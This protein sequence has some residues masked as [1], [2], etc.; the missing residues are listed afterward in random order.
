MKI[1]TWILMLGVLV[2]NACKPNDPPPAEEE[3]GVNLNI[4]FRPTFNAVQLSWLSQ[5]VTGSDDSITFDKVKFLL[6][7][8]TLETKD[9]KLVVLKDVFAYLSLKEGRDSVVLKRVPKGDYKSIRFQIGLDSEVNHSDPA[10]WALTD[11]LS[12][13]LNE[14]HWGWSGGYI[15][16]VIEGYYKNKGANA[17]Y[18][19]HIATE[20]YARTHSFIYDYSISKDA[21]FVFEVKM[22]KYFN[23]I[24][25][26]S[27][28]TDGSFS[29][30][31][32]TDPVMDK[33][34]QNVNSV[35]ELESFH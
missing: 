5:Y 4:K 26:Y 14:M 35:V 32:D 6:S 24:V 3:K 10:K 29:H 19:F 2:M 30:S 22:D 33:F 9:G 17:A 12:P 1:S 34:I 8:F 13:A 21:R 7:D 15:F 31:G 16:N 18:S 20:K 28:K 27:L 11:P 25:N 23:N